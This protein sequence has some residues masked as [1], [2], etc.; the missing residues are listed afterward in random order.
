MPQPDQPDFPI[1]Q[2]S[3]GWVDDPEA[4]AASLPQIAAHQGFEPD[5]GKIAQVGDDDDR[6]VFFW[7]A[8]KKVLGKVLSSWDQKDVGSCVSFGWG[9]GVQDLLLIQIANGGAEEWPGFEV[10][11]EPIYGGSRVE[12]G[13]GRI[14]GDGSVGAWAAKWCGQWGLSLRKKYGTYDLSVYNTTTCRQFGRSGVPAEIE[15]AAKAN[16]VRG[17]AMV[18][19]ADQAWSAIGSGYPIPVCSNVGF[20]SPLVNGFC[21]QRGSWGHCLELRARFIH[22][23]KGKC[24]VIQ[25]SWGNYMRATTENRQIEV[26]GRGKVE[27]PEGCF[28][29]TAAVVDKILRQ[30][31]SFAISNVKGFPARKINWEF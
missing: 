26:V 7:E 12:V 17:V 4:V 25:N 19:T 13:G 23:T 9:R 8:E 28:A 5:F 3:T 29:T 24:F 6:P 11:T 10:A 1:W 27:L 30:K 21:E 16:P 14:S 20:Q 2:G 18:T 31:D 15:E 22:P